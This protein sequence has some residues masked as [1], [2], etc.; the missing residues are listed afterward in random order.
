[1]G[2]TN[3]RLS[4]YDTGIVMEHCDTSLAKYILDPVAMQT[5]SWAESVRHLMDG[6]AGLS[7]IHTHK[8]TTHGD[9]K[10]DNL[11]I[12][13]G[14]LKVSDFGL[15]TVRRTMTK[16]TG[17]TTI[18]GTSSFMA[19]EMLL[20]EP[21]GA[22]PAID[23]WGFGCC[24]ANV[25]TG[26][27]PFATFKSEH[28]LLVALRQKTPVYCKEQV[29]AGSPKKLLDLIDKCC[30][31]N[32]SNRPSMMVVE[33]ELRSILES[34]Q[35]RDGFGLPPPWLERGC[36]IH[37]SGWKMFECAV[38][39]KDF[40]LIKTRLESEMGDCVTIL[41][42][43]MNVNID[44]FR[45]YHLERDR[46]LQENLKDANEAFLWHAT[47]EEDTI[48]QQGFDT[49]YCRLDFE[50]YGAGLYLAADSKMSNAYTTSSRHSQYPSDRSMLLCRVACGKMA[51]RPPLSSSS[52]Y[53]KLL[54]QQAPLQLSKEERKRQSQDKIRELL[55]MPKNRTCPPGFHS[56]LGVDMPN[57]RK[58]KTEIVVNRS[59][60]AFPAY[61]ISYRLSRALPSPVAEGRRDLRTFDDYKSSD[62]HRQAVSDRL[63]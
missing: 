61:R 52:E 15:A 17:M 3:H 35:T 48:L 37:D 30:D 7:F 4:C 20:G 19:P 32:A 5:F 51:E 21:G 43:E 60:Q 10:P 29:R 56:Q 9:V 38:G 44:L 53:Q 28:N 57:A 31:Y 40:E 45:R 63:L 13:Q 1:M 58:S 46:V 11:L 25:V 36:C 16:F 27:L 49:N 34:I 50:Y 24:I 22:Q 18:K 41:K 8:G 14:K 39:T 47:K 42:I 23:V 26:E 54:L 12:Q 6:A 59:Y 33:Q 55:R 2:H 62:F